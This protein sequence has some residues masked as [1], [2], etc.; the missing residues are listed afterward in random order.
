MSLPQKYMS[1]RYAGWYNG[2]PLF[3]VACPPPSPGDGCT[4]PNGVAVSACGTLPATYLLKV[5]PKSSACPSFL[6]SF[7]VVWNAGQSRWVGS[8]A[9]PGTGFTLSG[10][11]FC[12]GGGLSVSLTC[13]GITKT[14]AL[15]QT[16]EIDMT[17]GCCTGTVLVSV[18][19]GYYLG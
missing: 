2:R 16:N 7:P 10:V 19:A 6:V 8:V 17:G 5:V 18:A 15:D 12:A 14:V 3:V 1:S 11:V 13:G 4:D 9:L